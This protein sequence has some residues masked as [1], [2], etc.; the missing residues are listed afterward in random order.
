MDSG[1]P[2]LSIGNPL[3]VNRIGGA[4]IGEVVLSDAPA[5]EKVS[6]R[7]SAAAVADLVNDDNDF[8]TVVVESRTPNNAGYNNSTGL[9]FKSKESGAGATL[10]TSSTFLTSTTVVQDGWVDFGDPAV[11]DS[12][13]GDRL[14]IATP[15]PPGAFGFSRLAY[16]GFSLSEVDFTG[17]GSAVF[18]A[19]LAP[20]IVGY[21]GAPKAR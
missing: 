14:S 4:V 16:F 1:A 9:G 10:S 7:F 13:T 17:V 15:D 8:V 11:K 20:D 6:I 21:Q 5:S 3:T 2:G 12:G 18:K 19:S